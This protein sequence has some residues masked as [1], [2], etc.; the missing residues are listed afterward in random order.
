MPK[1]ALQE[2][3]A[4][5]AISVAKSLGHSAV[6][7]G[8]VMVAIAET[9]LDPD[10]RYERGRELRAKLPPAGDSIKLPELAK[11]AE[12]L[13]KRCK[14]EVAAI[15]ILD[16][17]KNVEP[18]E[19]AVADGSHEEIRSS[20]SDHQPKRAPS[21]LLKD[22]DGLV[23]LSAVKQQLRKVISV[24]EANR[25]RIEAGDQAVPQSLHLVFTGNPGTGK[26]TVARLVAQLYGATGALKGTKFK[27]ATRADLIAQYVG[28]TAQQTERVIRSVKP[29]VLFIDE[30]YS[31]TPSHHGDFAEECVATMVKSME[32]YRSEF[33]V[34]AAGYKEEMKTFVNSNPG[35][36]SRFQTFIHFDDYTASELLEIYRRFAQESNISL[37]EGV[38]EKATTAIESA[39][40]REGFGN[41]RFVRSLWEESFANMAVRAAE[42]GVTTSEELRKI[43]LEDVPVDGS[44][45]LG[46]N[47]RIG[48]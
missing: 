48:F 21:D 35:L 8:H 34:I 44:P 40:G 25:V 17:E 27:E 19:F 5:R 45:T 11:N 23:G 9:V 28:H 37:G 14:D 18:R 32:D 43:Q 3:L 46:Q 30:A 24:V 31:L 12:R 10:V 16:P 4:S 42:D 39:R 29:G 22:L 26:T 38:A 13:I 1:N 15:A 47:R 36:R 7:E 6:E 20:V 33:A 2:L 41:A